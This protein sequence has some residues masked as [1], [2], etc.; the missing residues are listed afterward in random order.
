MKLVLI[1]WAI[2]IGAGLV[3]D[4]LNKRNR[5]IVNTDLKTKTRVQHPA[6]F[7]LR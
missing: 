3:K 1:V 6:E 5:R 7:Q 2:M 4:V